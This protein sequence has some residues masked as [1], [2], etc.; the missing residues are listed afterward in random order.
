[1]RR[2]PDGDG[3]PGSAGPGAATDG[4]PIACAEP[5]RSQVSEPVGLRTAAVPSADDDAL[6]V[7]SLAPVPLGAVLVG[8]LLGFLL[9]RRRP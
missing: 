2:E 4:G 5:S 1:M 3:A 6:T 8:A 9:G 7:L